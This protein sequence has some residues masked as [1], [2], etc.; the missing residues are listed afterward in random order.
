MEIERSIDVCFK[1]Q[2]F[3]NLFV[4]FLGFSVISQNFIRP[5][6]WKKYRKE[7]YVGIGAANFLGDLGGLNKVG[8]DYSPIDLEFTET[9]T[10]F[11]IGYRY[12]LAKWFN[13]STQF[14]YLI[15]RGDDKLTTEQFRNN[16]NLNF[17]SNIFELSGRIEFVYMSNR[18]GH[19]YGIKRT[20][21]SRMK[22]RSWDFTV[23]MG[24]GGFYFNPKARTM[25]GQWVK[26]KPMH[27]EGQGL[28]GGPKQYG[29]Y[30]ICI[31]M[32]LAYRVYFNRKICVGIEA[33]FRKTFT[34]YI[35]DA[36]GV[37][38]DKN[39]IK[40]A[41]GSQAAYF[42]DPSKGKNPGQTNWADENKGSEAQVRGD[43]KQKDAFMSIQLT[44]GYILKQKRRNH[45]LRSK[46]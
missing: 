24:I 6:E 15:V 17:K 35:D 16:R 3:I 38:Y 27:T 31:P 11:Q 2:T 1:R 42:A 32:G 10:A 14:N 44:V 7:I 40:A 22:N 19:R 30:S 20:L 45:R 8:T 5:N 23:F 34:D 36:S 29:N 13:L 26:L 46:F 9:R 39:A 18:V 28:P 12:K 41:Y 37:Y 25:Q 43:S 33:N 21:S 4:L